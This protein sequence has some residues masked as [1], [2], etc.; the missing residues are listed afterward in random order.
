MIIKLLRWS[1][2]CDHFNIDKFHTL[3]A[4]DPFF[5]GNEMKRSFKLLEK[6]LI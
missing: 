2:C 1:Q 6:A 5:C 4:D 3:D